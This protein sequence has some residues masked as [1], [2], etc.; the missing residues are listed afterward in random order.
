MALDKEILSAFVRNKMKI[1]ELIIQ[2]KKYAVESSEFSYSDVP[3]SRPT[4]RGGVYF[5][6]TMAFK[7]KVFVSDLRLSEVLSKTMLGPNQEFAQ[8]EL[9]PVA[10][11]QIQIFAN[12]TNYVQKNTG[13]ELN[14]MIVET[15]SK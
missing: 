6:D 4:T 3:V 1:S 10:N 7:A 8:I 5:S 15:L 12:L 14:L 11:T 13:F 9:I 2:N